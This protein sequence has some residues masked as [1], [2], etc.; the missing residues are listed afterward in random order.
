MID[1]A[2]AS[3]LAALVCWIVYTVWP[4][5]VVVADGK[6]IKRHRFRTTDELPLA[7][8]AEIKFHYHAVV[9]FV[10]VWEFVAMSG[11]S[12]A[13]ETNSNV[14]PKALVA[15]EGVLPNFSVVAFERRFHE[16][17]VEDTLDVW[18]AP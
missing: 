11:R 7:E 14:M 6:I 3:V 17:D 9:G 4:E 1:V 5:R 8:L 13:V 15:L 10:G 18:K 12:F 2:I 16:G